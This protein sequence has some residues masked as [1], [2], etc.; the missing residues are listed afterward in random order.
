MPPETS[1]GEIS[2]DISGKERQGKKEKWSRKEGKSKKGRWKKLKYNEEKLKMRRGPL[3]FLSFFL[4][5][6]FFNCFEPK[7]E[8]LKENHFPTGIFFNYFYTMYMYT[9]HNHIPA[10]KNAVPF[11]NCV[12]ITDFHFASFRFESKLF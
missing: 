3:F 7:W 4:S 9:N 1:D 11:Q 6:F 5:F 8:P 2:A 12:Q 10:K